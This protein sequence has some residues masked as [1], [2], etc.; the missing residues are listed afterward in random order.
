MRDVFEYIDYRQLLKDLYED[1]KQKQSFFSYRYIAQKVGFSSAGFF[2]NIIQ[3]KRNIS[4]EFIF[5]FAEV[6]KLKKD[7]TGYFELLVNFDQAKDHNR[8]RYYFEKILGH[9]KSKIKI[10][11]VQQYEFYS[12]WYYTAVREIIDFL[13][14]KDDY[15]DLAKRVSPPIKPAEAKKAVEFMERTG[16]IRKNEDGVYEQADM[17]ISTGYEA[18]SV[19]ITNFL[20]ATCDLAREAVDR[21][22]REKRSMSTLT[23]TLS[24]EGFKAMEERLKSIRREILEI[25]RDDKGKRKQDRVYHMNFHLYPLS[26]V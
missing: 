4:P 26:K 24:E 22:P 3:G 8:R 16:L 20:M 1:R 2:T 14:F 15:E 6:F 21:Y 18:R 12:T 17:F 11:D 10:T 5:R 25:V 7:E 23:F 19:A 13:P 9:R